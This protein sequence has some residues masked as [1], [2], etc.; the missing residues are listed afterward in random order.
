MCLSQSL[1]CSVKQQQS[2]KHEVEG[3]PSVLKTA[4]KVPNVLITVYENLWVGKA[5]PRTNMPADALF[6]QLVSIASPFRDILQEG[7]YGLR[8]PG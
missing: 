2:P 5:R 1:Q 7:A 3:I 4:L 6:C 8:R